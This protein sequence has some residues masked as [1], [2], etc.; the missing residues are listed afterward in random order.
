[1]SDTSRRA[2]LPS[3]RMV[4]AADKA[5]QL[6]HFRVDTPRRV[7]YSCVDFGHGFSTEPRRPTIMNRKLFAVLFVVG[8]AVLVAAPTAFGQAPHPAGGEANLIIPDLG[9]VH[10]AG[11]N[12]RMLLMLGL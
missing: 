9:Q 8:L 7:T 6:K 4:P 10:V 12:G 5:C 1:M 11:A 3:T 2:S